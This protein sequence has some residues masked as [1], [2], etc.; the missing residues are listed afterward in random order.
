MYSYLRRP[1]KGSHAYWLHGLNHFVRD[2]LRLKKLALVESPIGNSYPGYSGASQSGTEDFPGEIDFDGVNVE[3]LRRNR[4][5][6][7]SS[8]KA[9][10]NL[11]TWEVRF[12]IPGSLRGRNLVSPALVEGCLKPLPDPHAFVSFP[13]LRSLLKKVSQA[14]ATS[15]GRLS[16]QPWQ[17][18][19]RVICE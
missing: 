17:V 2:R 16:S 12:D 11:G 18:S 19:A 5:L 14:H 4:Y 6:R 3:S 7:S 9:T 10:N 13:L 15:V 1:A 8:G